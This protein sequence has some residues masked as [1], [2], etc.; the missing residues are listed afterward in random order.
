MLSVTSATLAVA[1]IL[2]PNVSCPFGRVARR[3]LS[4][5][6]VKGIAMKRSVDNRIWV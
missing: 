4:S 6:L 3:Q 2:Q 5:G 1:L